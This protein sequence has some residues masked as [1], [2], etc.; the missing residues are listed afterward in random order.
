MAVTV[1]DEADCPAVKI[2]ATAMSVKRSLLVEVSDD[3]FVVSLRL[4]SDAVRQWNSWTLCDRATA[5]AEVAH[6]RYLGN[7]PNPEGCYPT[8]DVVADAERRLNF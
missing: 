4:L 1:A 8:L 6:D 2:A 3:G 7:Q 5:V